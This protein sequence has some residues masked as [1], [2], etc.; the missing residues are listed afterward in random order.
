MSNPQRQLLH[1]R[2]EFVL[3]G[4][5]AHDPSVIVIPGGRRRAECQSGNVDPGNRN[6]EV[7]A[8]RGQPVNIASLFC[9]RRPIAS[10]I[11]AVSGWAASITGHKKI[12]K[13][14]S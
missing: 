6:V 10:S 11:F 13:S 7:R 1:D 9:L 4:P 3:R 14:G 5:V 8:G 2:L 12:E